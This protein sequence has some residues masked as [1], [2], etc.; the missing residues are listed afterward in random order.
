MF[1]NFHLKLHAQNNSVIAPQVQGP[2]TQFWCLRIGNTLKNVPQV[3][4][5]TIHQDRRTADKLQQKFIF[6]GSPKQNLQFECE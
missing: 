1:F 6:L 2:D 3:E 4:V 5:C